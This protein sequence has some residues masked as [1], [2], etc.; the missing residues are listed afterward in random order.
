M[1]GYCLDLPLEAKVAGLGCYA[2]DFPTPTLHHVQGRGNGGEPPLPWHRNSWVRGIREKEEGQIVRQHCNG[3]TLQGGMRAHV[4]ISGGPSPANQ[5]SPVSTPME[6]AP[7]QPSCPQGPASQ[8]SVH[9][10][11]W[12]GK[13]RGRQTSPWQFKEFWHFHEGTCNI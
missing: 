2:H 10:V 1:I 3:R 5:A 9:S 12:R 7:Q 8:S 13:E 11:S 4:S 6:G